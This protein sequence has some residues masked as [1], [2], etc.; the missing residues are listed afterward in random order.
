MDLD[1]FNQPGWGKKVLR[2]FGSVT[3]ILYQPSEM[4]DQDFDLWIDD[5]TLVK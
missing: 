5:V 4:S 3:Q 2:D 1:S